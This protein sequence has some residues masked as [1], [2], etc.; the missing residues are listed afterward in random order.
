MNNLVSF[1]MNFREN[2]KADAIVGL[3]TKAPQTGQNSNRL[4]EQ[5]KILNQLEI[6]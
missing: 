5:L 3:S 4:I 6:A 2:K 1:A